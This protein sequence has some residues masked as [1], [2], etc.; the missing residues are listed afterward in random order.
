MIKNTQPISMSEAREY[1]DKKKESDAKTLRFIEKFNDIDV[2][3][4]KEMRKQLEEIDSA[5][6]NEFNVTKV[7]DLLPDNPEEVNKIFTDV[8]LDEDETKKIIEIV[9]QYK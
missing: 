6:L 1:L 2:K 8:G 3:K 4:A 7:I 5:K 9:K